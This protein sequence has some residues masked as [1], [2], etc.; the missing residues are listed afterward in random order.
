MSP[1]QRPINR[2]LA[3][4]DLCAGIV[5]RHAENRDVGHQAWHMAESEGLTMM[6]CGM[7]AVSLTARWETE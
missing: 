2:A 3:E 5:T 6:P 7:E 4:P 1:L